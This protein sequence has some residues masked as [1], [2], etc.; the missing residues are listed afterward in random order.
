[1][2]QCLTKQFKYTFIIYIFVFSSSREY[3]VFHL[4]YNTSTIIEKVERFDRW[5]D[6]LSG[7][8]NSC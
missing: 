8:L 7:K 4:D 1:M 3:A 6:S 2:R 5:V